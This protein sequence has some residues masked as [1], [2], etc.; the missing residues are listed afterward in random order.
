MKFFKRLGFFFSNFRSKYRISF[1]NPHNDREV[2]HI[3][4]SPLNIFTAA[5]ALIMVLFVAVATIIAF[6]PAL[7][8]IPG[9]PGNKTRNLLIEN[10]MRLDSL[11]RELNVWNNYYENLGRIMD[12]KAP[13]MPGQTAQDTLL[14]Q[15]TDIPRI[16]EDSILRSQMEGKG[17]YS[18][19]SSVPARTLSN[20]VEFYPPVKG[21]LQRKFD[22]KNGQ[23]G[24]NITT[25]ENLPVMAVADGTVISASWN[26]ADGSV[27]YLLHPGNI[28]SAYLHT[29]RLTKKAGDRVYS[30]EVIAFTGTSL[31][32]QADKGYIEVQLW[33]NGTPVDPENYIVF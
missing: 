12:G 3:Y 21:I 32:S 1:R 7:D 22:P 33:I 9:Y 2:W 26:P 28:I 10:N 4:L 19:Q 24:V 30:G 13:L 31:A 25:G 8:F 15:N 5:I 18:L 6:T 17:P 11:E 29:A 23:L 20:Y 16:E 14:A 27:M